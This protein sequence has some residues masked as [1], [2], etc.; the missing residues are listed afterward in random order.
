MAC[1][2]VEESPRVELLHTFCGPHPRL[3]HAFVSFFVSVSLE[4][5]LV[6]ASSSSS[7][8]S[9]AQKISHSPEPTEPKLGGFPQSQHFF[10]PHFSNHAKLAEISETFNMGVSALTY[11]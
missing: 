2:W 11:M 9:L 7:L 10:Q 4:R 5:S 6:C 8:S 3:P 1:R